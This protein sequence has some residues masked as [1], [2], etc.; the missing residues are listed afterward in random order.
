MCRYIF[1]VFL[2][3]VSLLCLTSA[4]DKRILMSDPTYV[5]QELNHLQSELQQLQAKVSTQEQTIA[6]QQSVITTLTSQG[7]KGVVYIRWGRMDCPEGNDNQLVYS[8]YAG[9]SWY[10]A[11]GAAANALCMP[12]DPSW[13]PHMNATLTYPSYLYGA[14]YDEKAVFGMTDY[15]EDVP[16][17]VCRNS[18]HSIINMVPGRTTCYPGWTEAY[19]GLLTSGYP[20]SHSA[21]EF[22]CMD[23][24]PQ[25]IVGGGNTNDNGRLFYAVLAQCGSLPCPPYVNNKVL[26]CVVCMI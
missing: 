20:K 22:L 13:G 6:S 11:S 4:N 5:A 10:D 12:P 14:E 24:N 26:S 15:N 1:T 3:I 9:G 8:G 23:G 16:C 18:A 25:A 2:S 17:A 21:N 7:G 19:G